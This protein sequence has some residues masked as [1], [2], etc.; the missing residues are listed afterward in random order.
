M[1]KCGINIEGIS[2]KEIYETFLKTLEFFEKQGYNLR[3]KVRYK[4][5]TIE[6]NGIGKDG[7]CA[8]CEYF[9]QAIIDH[10]KE[11]EVKGQIDLLDCPF[12]Q[13][14]NINFTPEG[15]KARKD[16]IDLFTKSKNQR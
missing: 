1:V 10:F 7:R 3:N 16:L 14:K 11:N 2:K 13:D 12:N 8:F 6:I 4:G 5:Y 15:Q 9:R